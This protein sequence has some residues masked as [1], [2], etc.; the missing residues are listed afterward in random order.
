MLNEEAKFG[1]DPKRNM[2]TAAKRTLAGEEWSLYKS[3]WHWK[4]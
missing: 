1:G 4:P 2:W 3:S